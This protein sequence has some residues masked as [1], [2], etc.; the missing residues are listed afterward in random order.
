MRK[1]MNF[2][3]KFIIVFLIIAVVAS[4]AVAFLAY[5]YYNVEE[6]NNRLEGKTYDALLTSVE[7]TQ[8]ESLFAKG[9]DPLMPSLASTQ[10]GRFKKVGDWFATMNNPEKDVTSTSTFE[11]YALTVLAESPFVKPEN[12]GLTR[13]DVSGC[14]NP[15]L[16]WC[17]DYFALNNQPDKQAIMEAWD[18]SGEN[19]Q[20]FGQFLVNGLIQEEKF[21]PLEN[22]NVADTHNLVRW[23]PTSYVTYSAYSRRIA[24]DVEGQ[25]Y[26]VSEGLFAKETSK[27]MELKGIKVDGVA[28]TISI[29]EY[30]SNDEK[31]KES[32]AYHVVPGFGNVL[33][34]DIPFFGGLGKELYNGKEDVL[35]TMISAKFKVD[36]INYE[37]AFPFVPRLYDPT[38]GY[39]SEESADFAKLSTIA[40]KSMTYLVTEFL[41]ANK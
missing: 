40:N 41:K 5:D 25:K 10:E 9:F 36:G 27:V 3:Q 1:K 28:V 37:I 11:S 26:P 2:S 12:Y 30:L 16:W 33:D 23:S 38:A 7:L 18:P 35:Y 20:F 4:G 34:D 31:I 32:L 6:V 19:E 24:R 29:C 21:F 39:G 17:D 15:P 22:Q 14:A 8:M 13:E